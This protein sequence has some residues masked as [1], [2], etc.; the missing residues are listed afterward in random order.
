M[1][2]M[3]EKV[4]NTEGTP[5]FTVTA[6]SGMSGVAIEVTGIWYS[7][8]QLTQLTDAVQRARDFLTSEGVI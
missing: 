8:N 3:I 2:Q 6:D 1:A 5:V 7:Q 4:L